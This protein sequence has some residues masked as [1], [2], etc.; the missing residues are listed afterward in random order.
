MRRARPMIGRWLIPLSIV[1]ILI[2]LGTWAIR[3]WTL[4]E[5]LGLLGLGIATPLEVLEDWV[6]GHLAPLT[7]TGFVSLFPVADLAILVALLIA[8]LILVVLFRAQWRGERSGT[9]LTARVALFRRPDFRMRVRASMALIAVV[10]LYL[11]WEI[12]AWRNWRLRDRYRRQA[13]H[14]A[15]QEAKYRDL[16]RGV[17]LRLAALDTPD[18]ASPE[19][20]WTPAARAAQR[21]YYR[22]TEIRNASQYARLV[23]VSGEL[24]RKY[25]RALSSPS[26]PVPP[27]PPPAALPLEIDYELFGSDYARALARAQKLIGLYPDLVQAHEHRAWILATCPDPRLRDGKLAVVEARR[28]YELTN[29]HPSQ[30]LFTLAAAHAAAGDFASAV[31][32]EERALEEDQLEWDRSV[33]EMEKRHVIIGMRSRPNQDRLNLYKAGKPYRM[34]R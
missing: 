32:W 34:E 22:D 7:P 18:S 25:E 13:D 29:G 6:K 24:R 27:D 3:P 31:R 12:V 23:V 19:N 10:A 9:W 4:H 8:L 33:A 1:L 30:V 5:W 26:Q 11:G 15:E 16:L 17:E 21:A 28:A 2:A 20:L 14:H